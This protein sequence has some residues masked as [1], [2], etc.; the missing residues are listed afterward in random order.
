MP[1]VITDAAWQPFANALIPEQKSGVC[2]PKSV[3]YPTSYIL[4]R[5]PLAAGNGLT[6]PYQTSNQ[7]TKSNLL[8]GKGIGPAA[9]IL[10]ACWFLPSEGVIVDDAFLS[11]GELEGNEGLKS[12]LFRGHC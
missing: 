1:H 7:E 11:F 5:H 2:W 4:G 10:S 8:L 9:F 6:Y 12:K 3:R